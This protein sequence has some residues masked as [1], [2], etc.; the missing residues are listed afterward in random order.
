MRTVLVSIGAFAMP[1][2]LCPDEEI[3]CLVEMNGQTCKAIAFKGRYARTNLEMSRSFVE[4]FD[5]DEAEFCKPHTLLNDIEPIPTKVDFNGT[6]YDA[7]DIGYTND[8][9]IYQLIYTIIGD[10]C[11]II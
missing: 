4:R 11:V 6:D 1:L 9:G 8:D 7:V 2:L 10:E 3:S 5:D